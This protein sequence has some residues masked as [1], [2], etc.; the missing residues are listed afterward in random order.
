MKST[1]MRVKVVIDGR[2]GKISF[3]MRSS[4]NCLLEA[5]QRVE[6][7]LVGFPTA[8]ISIHWKC[9]GLRKTQAGMSRPAY[10]AKSLEAKSSNR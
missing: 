6:N 5:W 8:T 9:S 1:N 10:F 3:F 4:A 2:F 7:A